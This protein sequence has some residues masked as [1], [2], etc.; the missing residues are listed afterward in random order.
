MNLGDGDNNEDVGEF[1]K[2]S[3]CVEWNFWVENNIDG[4]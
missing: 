3:L 4:V 2:V 1:I